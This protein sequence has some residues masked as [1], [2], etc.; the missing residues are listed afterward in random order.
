MRRWMA[1]PLGFAAAAVLALTGDPPPAQAQPEMPVEENFRTADG[2]RL[3]GLFHKSP[4]PTSGEPVVILLY[5]PGPGNSMDKP[6]DWSGLTKTLNAKGFHVFRFDW[7]GHGKSTDI[8]DTGEFWQTGLTARW[9]QK[10]VNGFNKKPIKN[11]ISIKSDIKPG[12]F[13]AYVN[14]LAA[15]RYHLDSKNDV[16]NLNTSSIY[17]IG[18][19]DTATLGMLWMTAE[20]VR[21]AIHP[22]LAGGLTYQVTP[23]SGIIVNPAAGADIAGAVWLSA[24]HPPVVP[25]TIMTSW[26]AKVALKLRDNNPMLFLYGEK[27]NAQLT[28]SKVFYDQVLVARGNKGLGVKPL[29][30]TFLTP[31][32]NTK[33]SGAALLG[34]NAAIGT[35]DTI[36][37]Y[38]EARQKDRVAIV[39]K[40]R[41]Y[42]GPYY[43]DLNYFGL[44]P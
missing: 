6:G 40:D 18:A 41:K 3:K 14:D 21:P 37:K 17:L 22:L 13:P 34:Q 29:D 11:D 39:R 24:N 36:L 16:G 30:Q 20:W 33:L 5:P 12:Y 26:T 42:P 43:I 19:G 2:V 23:M 4:S 1:A 7:R 25:A 10:Y 35:E 9:N 15:A 44:A 31:I 38:L 8:V 28:Q 32:T 27:D